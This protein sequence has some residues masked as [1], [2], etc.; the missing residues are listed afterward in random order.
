MT[1]AAPVAILSEAVRQ[2]GNQRAGGVVLMHGL[3]YQT[4]PEVDWD[5]TSFT[6]ALK[7][8]VQKAGLQRAAGPYY[9]FLYP[10]GYEPLLDIN[11][12]SRSHA[13][14]QQASASLA[15]GDGATLASALAL[16][17]H[18]TG[19]TV[20]ADNAIGEARTG[21]LWLPA[22]PLPVLLDAILK[23][24]RVPAADAQVESG[25][26]YLLLHTGQ[27]QPDTL[28]NAAALTPDL[29]AWLDAPATVYLPEPPAAS[30]RLPLMFA[31]RTLAESATALSQQ[32]G[33]RVSIEHG[34]ED[35]PVNQCTLINLPRHRVLDLLIRQ[36]LVPQFGY[37]VTP[38]GVTI[39]R[40]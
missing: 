40:R 20:V 32:L 11:M 29:R 36:W 21:E 39:R 24:A 12:A 34:I 7:D 15:L 8:I 27:P 4:I 25:E 23:S 38:E 31:P 30:G 9:D 37:E 19:V 26:N 17:S 22:S 33:M 2:I 28:L 3:G 6:D 5:K 16:L 10:A 18:S 14:V 13:S 1:Y 35:L